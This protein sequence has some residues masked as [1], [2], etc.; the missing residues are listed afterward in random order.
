M[1]RDPVERAFSAFNYLRQMNLEPLDSLEQAIVAEPERLAAHWPHSY[2]YLTLSRYAE[3]L[4]PYL[5]VFPREQLLL[6]GYRQLRDDP[7]GTLERV[8]RFA[9]LDSFSGYDIGATYNPS[10]KPRSRAV[11]ALMDLRLPRL[12]GHLRQALPDRVHRWVVTARDWNI[13]ALADIDPELRLRLIEELR[14]QIEATR[15]V[16]GDH[17]VE[18][19]TLG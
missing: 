18:G 9:D 10:G 13:E 12:R 19:W 5:E 6:L 2:G 15:E 1:L 7:A 8:E 4:A 16:A 14:P 3:L 17:V 11:Q